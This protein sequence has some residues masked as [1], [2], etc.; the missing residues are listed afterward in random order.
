MMITLR[1]QILRF[2]KM[3]LDL[4]IAPS[5]SQLK[6]L[7]S[8]HKGSLNVALHWLKQKDYIASKGKKRFYTYAITH[9]GLFH[10][11]QIENKDDIGKLIL[12]LKTL[13]VK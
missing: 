7:H 9:K 6:Y 4:D 11:H 8:K 10:L 3:S 2:L 5:Y 1:H 13:E 12:L